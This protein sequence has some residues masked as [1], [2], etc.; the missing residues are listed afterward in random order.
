MRGYW[1]RPDATSDALLTDP[2]TGERMLRTRDRFRQDADGLLYF[3]SRSDDIFKCRGEKVA[4]SLIEHALCEMPEV[5]E[6]AVVGVD[7]PNDGMA[8]KAIVVPRPG[9]D[10]TEARIRQHCKATL[11]SVFMPRFVELRDSLPKTDSGKLRRRD[12]VEGRATS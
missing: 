3:V 4:P 1:G 6:A 10:L 9:S 7:D 8:I 5:A 12:L 11:E 2:T